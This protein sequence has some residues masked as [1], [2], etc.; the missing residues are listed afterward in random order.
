MQSTLELDLPVAPAAAPHDTSGK[1]VGEAAREIGRKLCR[2]GLEPEWVCI[3]N[4]VGDPKCNVYG[5]RE[6]A[7][8]PQAGSPKE[9]LSLSVERRHSEGWVIHIEYIAFHAKGEGG[10]WSSVPLLRI[11][12]LT[13]TLAWSVAAVVSRL[14]DID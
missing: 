9:R 8:W 3:S 10:Y 5:L 11:K 4:F 2:T 13:R 14:L 12:T 1:T 6:T 7:P